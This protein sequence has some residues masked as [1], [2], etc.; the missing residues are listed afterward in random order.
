VNLIVHQGLASEEELRHKALALLGRF[1]S[2]KEPN[3]RYLGL[4]TMARLAQLEGNDAIKKHEAIVLSNLH[5]ADISVRRRSLDLLFVMC[6]RDNTANIVEE[7]V[8]YLA[9]AVVAIRE[10]MV[11]KIAIVAEKYA[12][13]LEWYVTTILRL[14]TL[15]GDHVSDDIW[16]R[17]IIMVTNHKDLQLFAAEKLFVGLQSKRAHET[18]VKVGA[19]VLGEFGFLIADRPGRSGEDQL[20]VLMAHFTSVTHA[21]QAQML[22]SLVKIGNLYEECRPLVAPVFARYQ[23]HAVLELQQRACEYGALP[24]QGD[25]MMEDVLREMPAWNQVCVLV[26]IVCL[27]CVLCRRRRRRRRRLICVRVVE[28]V[29]RVVFCRGSGCL[30]V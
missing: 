8:T 7:L 30:G 9:A 3:M 22:S 10:E 19:Y 20:V 25:E 17:L 4:Q 15:A 12:T 5:D 6:D 27:L 23:N 11:L 16:H 28:R 18:L 21:T 13:D 29:E 24:L 2:T 1:I 26:S 14:I